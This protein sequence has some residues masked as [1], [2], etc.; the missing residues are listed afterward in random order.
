MTQLTALQKLQQANRYKINEVDVDIPLDD[1][2]IIKA[3]LISPDYFQMNEQL[4]MLKLDA[5]DEL[6]ARGDD[7]KPINTAKWQEEIDGLK[8]SKEYKELLKVDQQKKLHDIEKEKPKNRAEQRAPYMARTRMVGSV[9]PRLLRDRETNEILFPTEQEVIAVSLKIGGS[10]E[11]MTLLST[12]FGELTTKMDK[13][14][15]EVDSVK[16]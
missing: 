16:N 8:N 9:I 15:K 7:K 5:M 3:K 6:I 11:L 1:N 2:E 14:K 12:A 10:I 4:E 13:D